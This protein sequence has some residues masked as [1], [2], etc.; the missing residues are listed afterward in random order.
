MPFAATETSPSPNS[1]PHSSDPF[2]QAV[3]LQRTLFKAATAPGM[4]LSDIASAA[5]AWDALENRKRVMK[6]KPAPKAVDSEVWKAN[7][8]RRRRSTTATPQEIHDEKESLL[9]QT[10]T[11]PPPVEGEKTPE[12]NLGTPP[13]S[14][15]LSVPASL[16]L[17]QRQG[18]G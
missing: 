8:A 5:K 2:K 18:T 15:A 11:A 6:M 9:S 3:E 16:P 10:V 4:K 14:P 12:R 17:K 13:S 1:R 7:R